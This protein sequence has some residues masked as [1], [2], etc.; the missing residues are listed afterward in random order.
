MSLTAGDLIKAAM[1][2]AQVLQKGE[3][4]DDGEM[5]DGLQAMSMM[6][7][8]WAAKKLMVR[9]N[10]QESFPLSAG[11]ASYTIGVGGTFNTSKPLAITSAFLRDANNVDTGI[12]V[13]TREVY[14]SYQDKAISVARPVA[15]C[16]DPGLA[17]QAVQTGTILVY[18]IPDG[19]TP[20]TL[21]IDSQKPF[22]EI[23][24]I[25]DTMTFELP[26]EEAIKYE[27]A[28]RLWPEYHK[29]DPP[30]L[31]M[32]MANEAMHTVET[33]NATPIIAGLDLP[34]TKG[35]SYNIYTGGYND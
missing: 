26:Y 19:I 28:L 16:Y 32:M 14:D 12:D 7:H 35:M 33:M 23:T 31:L 13:I 11:V 18:Y 5:Q 21:F 22:T 3:D 29:G 4:P 8:S 27:L 34:G 10:V 2:L 9:A 1:R 17:Q 20:Y 25:T 24:A 30:Q 15:I 6:L